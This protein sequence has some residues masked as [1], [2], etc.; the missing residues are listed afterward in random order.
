MMVTTT[1]K[2]PGFEVEKVIGLVWGSSIKARHV[3]K[4]IKMALKHIVGGE[5]TDYAEMMEDARRTALSRMLEHARQLG[6]D[7]VINIRMTTSMVMS[8][9]AEIII[10]GTAVKLKKT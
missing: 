3:G 7:A 5:L 2:V 6:A 1:E 10:Y 9:A 8:G 4:D